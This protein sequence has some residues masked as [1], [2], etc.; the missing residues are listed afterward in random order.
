MK[1]DA[2]NITLF[3]RILAPRC[4][5]RSKRSGEQCRKAAMRGK[6]VCR[7]HGGASTGPKTAYGR[8][9]CAAAKTVH[10]RE[11]REI[12][13]N[14]DAKLRELR[15]VEQKMKSLGMIT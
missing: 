15:L 1:T 7:M 2:L 10:G 8:N 12:R 6:D 4:N 14:R 5:A 3:G 11:T 9:R 13:K